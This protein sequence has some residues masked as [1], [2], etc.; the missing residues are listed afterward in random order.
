MAGKGTNMMDFS[1]SR[2]RKYLNTYLKFRNYSHKGIFIGKSSSFAS[3][4]IIGDGSRINGKLIAKGAGKLEIGRFCAIGDELDIITSNQSSSHLS[5]QLALQTK[6]T[7]Q[8]FASDKTDVTIGSDV[9]IGDRVIIL[10]GITI[11]DGAIIGAGSVVTNDVPAFWVSAGVPA[12]KIK[13]RSPDYVRDAIIATQWWNL[14]TSELEKAK[15]LFSIDFSK[16]TEEEWNEM[17]SAQ[18]EK[19]TGIRK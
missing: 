11:G 14:S 16:V 10:P 4:T 12:K 5:I 2:K 15:E 19:L 8:C 6:L 13:P 1:S 17:Y 9:W 18:F 3:P 7:K